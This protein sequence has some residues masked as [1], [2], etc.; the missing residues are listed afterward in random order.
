MVQEEPR[1][2]ELPGWLPGQSWHINWAR[3][4]QG[5]KGKLI[6]WLGGYE[7]LVVQPSREALKVAACKC[8]PL[9]LKKPPLPPASKAL[10]ALF[11]L[12]PYLL[13][14]WYSFSDPLVDA[15]SAIHPWNIGIPWDSVLGPLL[16]KTISIT[17]CISSRWSHILWLQLSKSMTIANLPFSSEFQAS[18][19]IT[20]CTSQIGLWSLP[21]PILSIRF[22][23]LFDHLE[24]R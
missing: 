12:L 6:F 24:G 5:E 1:G 20:H 8:W 19:L 18:Y 16:F 3:G 4:L 17:L 10:R 21:S 7:M 9:L 14:L 22:S 13:S 2:T 11:C 23:P 15:S